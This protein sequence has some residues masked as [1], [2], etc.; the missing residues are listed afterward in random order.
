MIISTAQTINS[1]SHCLVEGN[2]I[3]ELIKRVKAKIKKGWIRTEEPYF[4]SF[5]DE[6]VI[7]QPMRKPKPIKAKNREIL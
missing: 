1:K 3:P 2:S 5:V 4:L 6:Q 7:Y